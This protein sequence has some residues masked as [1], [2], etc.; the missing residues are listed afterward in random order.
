MTLQFH[1]IRDA[2]IMFDLMIKLDSYLQGL[3]APGFVGLVM[4]A[5]SPSLPHQ[6]HIC[7]EGFK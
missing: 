4:K 5:A 3:C 7:L 6:D 1:L 2:L